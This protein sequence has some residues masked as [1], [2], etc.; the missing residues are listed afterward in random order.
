MPASSIATNTDYQEGIDLKILRKIESLEKQVVMSM[1][2]FDG[3]HLG[4]Q[5]I[6]ERVVESARRIGGL[7]VIITFDPH[8]LQIVKPEICP[9]LLTN[10]AEKERLVSSL[11]VDVFIIL[12][13]DQTLAQIEPREFLQDIILKKMKLAGICVGED[14]AFGFQ[15]R[16]DI[17]FLRKIG[18]ENGFWVE[19]IKPIKI[20]GKVVS[21]TRIR[22]LISEGKTEKAAAYLGRR[23]SVEGGVVS[24]SGRGQIELGYPTVNLVPDKRVLLPADGVYAVKVEVK[25]TTCAGMAYLGYRTTFQEKDHTFEVYLF[26]FKGNLYGQ[27]LRVY[28][29]PRI[30]SEMT[31]QDPT[32]LK[33]QLE[34]DEEIVR[35]LLIADCGLRIADYSIGH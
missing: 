22:N 23:P 21:S 24:G 6:I 25:G 15:R 28:F 3:L 30:R 34:R 10:L 2:A 8:P 32:E 1:G 4:H 14:H 26:D 33:K 29:G 9:P 7:S 13:F 16:G 12:T 31:F 20:K 17:N 27:S 5:R 35:N 18:E 19:I 11:G